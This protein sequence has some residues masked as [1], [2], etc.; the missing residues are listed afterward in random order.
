MRV[1]NDAR[2]RLEAVFRE[3]DVIAMPTTPMLPYERKAGRKERIRRAFANHVHTAPFNHSHN[4]AISLPCDDT[5]KAPVG[6]QLVAHRDDDT[7]LL[8][9]ATALHDL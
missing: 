7:R 2:E 5:G 4:P 9:I 8:R 6:V 3:Y 1:L